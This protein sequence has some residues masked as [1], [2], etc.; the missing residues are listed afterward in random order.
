MGELQKINSIYNGT[1]PNI[2]VEQYDLNDLVHMKYAL[3]NLV[4]VKKSF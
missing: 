4:D 2:N 3:I 1:A